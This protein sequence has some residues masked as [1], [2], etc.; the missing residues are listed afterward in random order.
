M[1]NLKIAVLERGFVYV[2][3]ATIDAGTIAIADAQCIRRWGTS[4]GLGQ[5]ALEGPQPNTRLD[6]AGQVVAPL[7]ALIHTIDCDADKWPAYAQASAAPDAA[8]ETVAA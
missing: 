6:K 3:R 4:N 1:S 8:A 2:G 5:L 7:T